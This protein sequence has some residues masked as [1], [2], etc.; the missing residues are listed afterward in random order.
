M[1]DDEVG[2]QRCICLAMPGDS[3]IKLHRRVTC[4]D[5][6]NAGER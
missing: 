5:F 2:I 3:V 4:F 6:L 1:L